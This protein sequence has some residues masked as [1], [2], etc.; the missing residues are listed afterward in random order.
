VAPARAWPVLGSAEQFAKEYAFLQLAMNQ[1]FIKDH[2]D[3]AVAILGTLIRGCAFINDPKNGEEVTYVLE[4][5][6]RNKPHIAKQMYEIEV[7]KGGA[8]PNRCQV[9]R[10]GID[11]FI[12][13]AFWTKSISKDTKVPPFDEIVDQ[14]FYGEALAWFNNKG[15]MKK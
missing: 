11:A 9:T 6:M 8:I 3:K 5:V 13:S 4:K 10:K 7:L 14:K 1:N 12:E 15:W 2:H